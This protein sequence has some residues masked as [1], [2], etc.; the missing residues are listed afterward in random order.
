[1]NYSL[2]NKE[3]FIPKDQ[4]TALL[5]RHMAENSWK[6]VLLLPPDITHTLYRRDNLC[7]PHLIVGSVG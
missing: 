3:Q 1:M 5:D 2:Q 7:N 4:I 6:S